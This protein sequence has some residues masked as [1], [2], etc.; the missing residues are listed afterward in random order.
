MAERD[1]EDEPKQTEA[2]R[3]VLNRAA[4]HVQSG[5]KTEIR[6]PNVLVALFSESDSHAVAM[7]A[8]QG[9]EKLD[10]TSFIAHGRRKVPETRRLEGAGAETSEGKPAANPLKQFCVNLNERAKAGKIDPLIGRAAELERT[11]QVLA[12]RRKN[13][14]LYLGDAGVGKPPSSRASPRPSSRAMCPTC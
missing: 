9:I 11:I 6:G 5:G 3:R 2:F 7:L 4:L 1:G 10:V 14:P 12:R 8:E 13:N